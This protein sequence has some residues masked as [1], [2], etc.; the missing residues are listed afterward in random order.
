MTGTSD[1]ACVPS[2]PIGYLLDSYILSLTHRTKSNQWLQ[3]PYRYFLTG[4][5]KGPVSNEIHFP[6][7]PNVF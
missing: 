2:T 4:I 1:N 5:L 7:V 3:D 6:N